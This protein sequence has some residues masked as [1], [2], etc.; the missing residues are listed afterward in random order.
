M[1]K[2]FL[3]LVITFFTTV[4]F[5]QTKVPTFF[6]DNMILQQKSKVAIWGNDTPNQVV[7]IK[8]SWGEK[9][10]SKT[11]VNGNWKIFLQTTDAGEESYTVVIKG[12]EQ[13]TLNNVLL[14]EVWLCLG[15]SN[16]GWSL[17]ST[18]HGEED[19]KKASN[20]NLRIYQ[21][22]RQNW[23]KPLT[24]CPTGSWKEA[25]PYTALNTSAV[26]YYFAERLQKELGIP[27]GIIVQAYAGTPIEGWLPWEIQQENERSFSHKKALDE[28]T[29]R[30]IEKLG[31]TKE[32]AFATY[33]KELALYNK[34]MAANDTMKTKNRK[35]KAPVIVKP[36]SLGN[37]YPSN[38][39]NAMVHP[40]L[41]FGIKGIIWYQGER[42]SKSVQQ[43][44]DFKGQLQL[45]IN[46]YRNTW[47]QMSNGN[48]ANDFYFSMTQLPSWNPAQTKPV[49]GVEASWAVSRNAM[50]EII[51]ETP[52]TG[53][54]VSIDTGDAFLLHPQNKKPIGYRHAYNVLHDV[55]D[56]DIVAH[57]P[58]FESQK[59]DKNKIV[60]SFTGVGSGLMTGK[61]GGLNSFAIAGKNQK[62][63]WADAKIVGNTIEVSSDKILSPVAVRYAWAMNPS[64]RN[65]LYN[66]E[67]NPASPFR[68]DSWDLFKEGSEEVQVF[69]P[70]KPKGYKPKDWY[71][72][73]MQ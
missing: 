2:Y 59:I 32:K 6:G 26:S 38:I 45:L 17:E 29:V 3:L 64:E 23:Y 39:Y 51:S 41:G 5:A 19:A 21:S 11:D 48:V 70:K 65:L 44:L 58:Y 49:E 4:S 10:S 69:K 33:K 72:P 20:K 36:A 50:F 57:G 15:Q 42:N 67:G 37:Q 66:K 9:A 73:K 62:W 12:S 63:E 31:F 71:R 53:L 1:K 28:T 14:G 61:K 13:I 43:A 46:F 52:N 7:E 40:L 16:M 68:T 35:R 25:K 24:D 18:T 47:H 56:K 55:Y 27:V 60:L 22:D 54:V 8:T 34:Q 30:Q